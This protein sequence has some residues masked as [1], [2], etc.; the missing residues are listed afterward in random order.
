MTDKGL[1]MDQREANIP[2]FECMHRGKVVERVKNNLC[3]CRGDEVKVFDCALHGTC[4]LRKYNHRKSK[5]Q[6]CL[7]CDD[8]ERNQTMAEP[9]ALDTFFEKVF[10]VNL[11]RR[12]DRWEEFI[13]RLPDDWPFQMPE[14]F[15]AIDGKKVPAPKWWKQGNGAWGC[16][17]SHLR[18]LEEAMN[19]DWESVL[20]MEDDAKCV[21]NFTEDVKEYISQIPS[22]WGMIYLGGQHLFTAKVKPRRVSDWVYVPYNVNR[23][24]A[25]AIHR[26]MFKRVYRWLTTQDWHNGHHIDHHLGRLHSERVDPIY[27][28]KQWLIAQAA[29]VSNINGRDIRED[30]N[31]NHAETVSIGDPSRVGFAVVLGTHASG[32]SCLAMVLHKLGVHMGNKFAYRKDSGEAVALANMLESAIP[33]IGLGV[34]MEEAKL[35][36]KLERWITQKRKEAMHKLCLPGCKYPTLCVLMH[37]VEAIVGDL[38]KVVHINRPLEDSIES[39]AR[40]GD[41][42]NKIPRSQVE[43]H[44]QWL[45][46]GKEAFLADFPRDRQ[47][48]IEFEDLVA[49]PRG[50]VE[51]LIPFLE[52]TPSEDQIQAAIDHVNPDR[53]HL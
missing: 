43:T 31:W 44:Q 51:R 30:R 37:H 18:I 12:E 2:L 50:Q 45:H 9:Q 26:R 8:R 25:F 20:F 32:S 48:T 39:L 11:D 46:K 5:H 27:C 35:H 42:A 14:R 17:R 28:P 10:C 29:G 49:D 40:R 38:L 52:I 41:V 24:H 53:K 7:T 13:Q 4:V 34:A 1:G 21:P 16:Y 3:G 22:D 19:N 6:I 33:K 47:I 23:T 15:A 36:K